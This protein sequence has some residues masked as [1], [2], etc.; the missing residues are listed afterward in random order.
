MEDI[1]SY[2]H[3]GTAQN[4]GDLTGYNLK[5]IQIMAVP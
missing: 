4:L 3:S 1:T 5:D 2:M